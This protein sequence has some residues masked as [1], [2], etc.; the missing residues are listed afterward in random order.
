MNWAQD[1]AIVISIGFTTAVNNTGLLNVFTMQISVY[2]EILCFL[3]HIPL[4]KE[5]LTNALFWAPLSLLNGNTICFVQESAAEETQRL[6]D[7]E[8][9]LQKDG[10]EDTKTA[11]KSSPADATSQP[12]AEQ[13][14]EDFSGNKTPEYMSGNS[15]C[16][17]EEKEKEEEKREEGEEMT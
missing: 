10:N 15:S 13:S 5:L 9:Y 11:A 6:K 8:N 2:L 12:A 17:E 16:D 14:T 4:T 7:W 3:Q 1:G